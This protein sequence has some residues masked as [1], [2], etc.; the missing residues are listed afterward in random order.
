MPLSVNT[1]MAALRSLTHLQ[2]TNRSLTDTFGRISSG[3]RIAKASDDAAGLAVAESLAME[4]RGLDQAR[5]NIE[6]G[7]SVTEI[8]EGAV[9]E[10]SNII[11]R[12]RELAIQSSSESLADEQRAYIQQETDELTAEITRIATITQFNGVQLTDGTATHLMIHVGP[13]GTA[14][15]QITI[16]LPDLT[17]LP[18]IDLS[19]AT[20]A[21][22][23]I[24]TLD[25]FMDDVN[26]ARATLGA[27]QSRLES[28]LHIVENTYEAYTGAESRI[29]DADFAYETAEMSRYTIL[30]NAGMAT[31]AQANQMNQGA[32]AL[33]GG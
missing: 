3:T 8:A 14:D 21:F 23:A 25:A 1:N 32:L 18:T 4:R 22:A 7:V 17:T 6:D 15:D 11:K 13:D 16:A 9:A 30:Q 2:R 12:L 19:T 26:S 10:V 29:R 5:R 31:L 24:S 28:A 33:L 20:S 27:G